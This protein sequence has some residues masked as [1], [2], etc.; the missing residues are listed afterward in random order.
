M[1]TTMMRSTIVEAAVDVAD[2]TTEEQTPM[3]LIISG[4]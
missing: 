1:R 4:T 2:V 3:T